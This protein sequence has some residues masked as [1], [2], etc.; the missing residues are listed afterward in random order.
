MSLVFRTVI[1]CA[2]VGMLISGKSWASQAF[3]M[4][5]D[6]F[7]VMSW[8]SIPEDGLTDLSEC[9][10]T[11]A[12]FVKP[13]VLPKCEELGIKAIV[14]AGIKRNQWTELTDEQIY[15]AMKQLVEESKDSPAVLGYYI[16]DE[17]GA[18][19]FPALGKAV[20]AIKELAPGKLAY[21]NLFPDYATIGAPDI[22]QL[23]TPSYTDYLERYVEEVKPQFISYDNYK[24]QQSGDL[25]NVNAA[26][27]YYRNLMEIRRV[28]MK[29][30]LPF[31]NIVSSN[32]I[33]NF[34]PIPS[35]ANL[36]FQAYTT[37][38]AGGKNV[39]WYTYYG[40]G[41]GYG[42]V[43]RQGNKTLSWNYLKMVNEQLK[44]IGP[45]MSTLKST[46]VFFT[47]PAPVKT[48][49]TLPG[50]IVKELSTD[51]PMMVGEFE[52][53]QAQTYVMVV[54]L[55]LNTSAKF[56]LATEPDCSEAKY[57]SAVDGSLIPLDEDS[58]LWLTAG[59]G[60][61]IQISE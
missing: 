5:D 14:S 43:N 20:A 2:V 57:V 32:Q 21:I 24:V 48:L 56:K 7:P 51:V 58:S 40:R 6:F 36:L 35:P 26:A 28:A 55:S 46:G 41:Y 39:T 61:L 23:E 60:V 9:G 44:V 8:D 22:S 19:F 37:L 11:V 30:G 15:D 34:T 45:V 47:S 3:L 59:Q 38:A 29:H 27:S 17:P 18:S 33:R 31:W 49:P 25:T 1:F 10:F 50:N 4:P 54:N 42:P 16:V 12:G 53:E 52:N 13:E